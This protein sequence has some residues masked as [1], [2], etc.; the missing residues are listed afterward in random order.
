M[1]SLSKVEWENLRLRINEPALVG[2][3]QEWLVMKALHLQNRK[4]CQFGIKDRP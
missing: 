2:S 4:A 3:I 1:N